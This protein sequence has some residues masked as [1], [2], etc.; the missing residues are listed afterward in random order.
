MVLSIGPLASAADA[1]EIYRAGAVH[2]RSDIEPL[3]PEAF[4]TRVATPAA[5]YVVEHY[6]ARLDGEPVGHLELAFSQADNLGTVDVEL[7]VLPSARRRGAGRALYDLAVERAKAEGRVRLFGRTIQRH[8][9]GASFAAAMGARVGLE[10][11]R[12]RLDVRA[13]DQARLDAEL[14]AAWERAGGYHL[15]QWTGVAPDEI[16][17]EV[18][19][20]DST[21][22]TEAPTGDLDWEPER[23]DADRLRADEAARARRGRMTF[24]TGALHGA[25]LVAWTTLNCPAD[26]PAHAWQNATLVAPAHRGHRLGLLI[27]LAN[28]AQARTHRP[29]IEVIDT[30]NA[31]TN[32]HMMRINRAMGFRPV[33]SVLFWQRDL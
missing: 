24:H 26:E 32:E 28:L 2:D 23:I 1:Y 31:A 21:F 10:E 12:S 18:A 20:L 15:I 4:A 29:A 3:S 13:A 8:P 11:I 5:S 17:D 14:A 25:R 9:D 7:A 27:K 22:M 33:E 19:A 30:F 6:L 16:I